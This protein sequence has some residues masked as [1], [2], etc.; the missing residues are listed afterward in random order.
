MEMFCGN[1]FENH[2]EAIKE[3]VMIQVENNLKDALYQEGQWIADYKRLRVVGIKQ[4]G[5]PAK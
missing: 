2:P 1:I 4:G 3:R 5:I